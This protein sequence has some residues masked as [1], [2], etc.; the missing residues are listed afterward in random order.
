MDPFSI[1][2]GVVGLLDAVTKC[3]RLAKKHFGPSSHSTSDLEELKRTLYQLHGAVGTFYMHIKLYDDEEEDCV[4][5]LEALLPV[6]DRSNEALKIIKQFLSSGRTSKLFGGAKFDKQIKTALKNLD[7][8]RR[9]FSEAVTADQQTIQLKV[10]NYVQAISEDIKDV[11]AAHEVHQKDH[12]HTLII[13]WLGAQDDNHMN[14]S[15]HEANVL[16]RFPSSGNS[17]LSNSIFLDWLTTT[18]DGMRSRLW[19]RA[20]PGT[21][22]SFLCS[23]AIEHVA[24]EPNC[25]ALY[26]F[27]RFDDRFSS[28]PGGEDPSGVVRATALLV[29]QLFQHFWRKDHRIATPV[30]EYVRTADRTMSHLVGITRLILQHGLQHAQ[31]SDALSSS[32][33]TRLFLF[34]DGIES[35]DDKGRNP[36]L[37]IM[38]LFDGAK[39]LGVIPK[40][41][42]SSQETFPLIE[43]MGMWASIVGDEVT[44]DDVK[45]FLTN[46]VPKLSIQFE[47]KQDVDEKPIDEWVLQKLQDKARGNFLY[48]KL[49][50]DWLK[51]DVFTVDDIVTLMT[52]KVPD[53][54]AEIYKQIFLKYQRDQLRYVSLL[55]SLVAFARRPLRLLEL[56]E[57]MTLALSDPA[58]G[59][60]LLRTPMALR[61]LFAPLIETQHDPS[62]PQ[63]PFCRLCH[64]T[65]REFLVKNPNILD[66]ELPS[67]TS[68]SPHFISSVRIG[69]LFFNYLSLQKYSSLLEVS[70]DSSNQT[71][72]GPPNEPREHI[73][74]PYCAKFW[75]RHLDDLEATPDLH[76]R[77]VKFLKSPNFQTLLQAQSLLVPEGFTLFKWTGLTNEFKATRALYRP[78]FPRWYR[79]LDSA[80][81][82][83]GQCRECAARR[84]DYRHF[85]DEWAYLLSRS[86]CQRGPGCVLGEKEHFFGE[87]DTCLSGM[88]GPTNFMNGM[89][90]KYPSFMLH[91]GPFEYHMSKNS[92][93]AESLSVADR[94]FIVTVS[95]SQDVQ[96]LCVD[97]WDLDSDDNPTVT[98]KVIHVADALTSGSE[99]KPDTS[100]IF[101]TSPGTAES[102]FLDNDRIHSYE[103][104]DLIVLEPPRATRNLQAL[105]V[106]I[107]RR[108]EI[109]VVAS[110]NVYKPAKPS[111]L[112]TKQA[113]DSESNSSDP[114][115]SDCPD[116]ESSSSS[117]DEFSAYETYSEGST[118]VETDG[119]SELSADEP[120]A[121][122][123]KSESE[124]ETN[125]E[126]VHSN[127]EDSESE[128][129]SVPKKLR[130]KMRLPRGKGST[131]DDLQLEEETGNR[132]KTDRPTWPGRPDRLREP[133]DR[134]T[135]DVVVYHVDAGKVLP[136][137]HYKHDIPA[138]LYSSPPAL[139]P[140]ES[141]FVW[142]LGGGEVLFVDYEAKTYF[143]RATMPTTRATRQ[144]CMRAHFSPCGGYLHI[145]SVEGRLSSPPK[146]NST[147]LQNPNHPSK[148]SKPEIILSLFLTTHR[149]SARKPTHSPPKL[150][151]K[152]KFTFGRFLGFSL[153]RLPF[154][155]TWTASHLH[156]TVSDYKLNLF[157]EEEAW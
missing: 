139:H 3:L 103:G 157:P 17:L 57:A 13:K 130:K 147:N 105:S 93:V 111:Q 88:L 102:F 36:S 89:K 123:D 90:E 6:V 10:R 31:E 67:P 138:M 104:D 4:G 95:S 40:M 142:P 46:S 134:L 149:L 87:I 23:S 84:L 137:F 97:V 96:N 86:G 54:L 53:K 131:A 48:A 42:I 114:E 150:I 116:D 106:D 14:S 82:D 41:W 145:A 43:G 1:S 39:E 55:F 26:Q 7:E 22:K 29:H 33:P 61:R 21:G 92:V 58:K 19:L 34:L 52:S 78:V 112:R 156:F 16:K 146:S 155:F 153:V 133:G 81:Y 70:R 24:R 79:A 94:K 37:G 27:F 74:L 126:A 115:T 140:T 5:S 30:S 132:K 124:S 65:V 98:S 119:E 35:L 18:D 2:V 28:G 122:D 63:N 101:A 151:H 99:T 127:L 44:L 60:D 118:D 143:I 20:P 100:R 25:I 69:D 152:A 141:L 85:I 125:P 32:E 12:L 117:S 76:D 9:V 11:Q 120:G 113:E 8:A 121:D 154:T 148:R 144:I 80:V 108:G 38:K 107:D 77:L 109:T 72:I 68:S 56:R 15:I 50:I 47:E 83:E 62:E 91:P 128:S 110:R 129:E 71:L 49:M 136:I 73:L 59:L 135:A 45:H 51:E 64:S 75:V 66:N